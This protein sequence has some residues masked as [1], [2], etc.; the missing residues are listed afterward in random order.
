M[1]SNVPFKVGDY[2]WW[3]VFGKCWAGTVT[4][5][6][7]TCGRL[8]MLKIK[9]DVGVPQLNLPGQVW[10][11]PMCHAQQEPQANCISRGQECLGADTSTAPKKPVYGF[12]S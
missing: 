6:Y 3:A 9:A 11:M 2:V 4:E 8:G 5:A 12:G 7:N 10:T 1:E